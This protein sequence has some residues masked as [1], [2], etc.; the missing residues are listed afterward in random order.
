[1]E[2]SFGL[3]V[4][5]VVVAAVFLAPAIAVMKNST[6]FRKIH[7]LVA[8]LMVLGGVGLIG[9]AAWLVTLGTDWGLEVWIGV[10]GVIALVLVVIGVGI[11]VSD[12]DIG[13]PSQWGLFALPALITVVVMTSGPTWDYVSAQFSSNA[14]TL[15]SQVEESK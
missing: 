8:V 11:G 3:V 5:G 2:L 15:K 12:W 4:G 10:P 6:L 1:M 7:F 9:I 14:N 13:R